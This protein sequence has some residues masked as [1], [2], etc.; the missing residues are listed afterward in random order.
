MAVTTTRAE[1]ETLLRQI[2]ECRE[3][4][5]V[6]PNL[7][8][9]KLL[10][11]WNTDLVLMAQA[12]SEHGVRKSGVH[13][14]DEQGNLR[15]P[16]GTYLDGYLRRVGYSIDP[17]ES[18]L[19]R[20]YSTNVLHCWP[21]KG[22]K[23]DRPPKASELQNCRKWWQAELRLLR[24]KAIVL[25]GAPAAEAFAEAC[26]YC[27]G[28]D[29]L[30]VNQDVQAEFDGVVTRFFTVPHPTAPFKGPLGGRSAYFEL[31]F[32]ALGKRLAADRDVY[33][34]A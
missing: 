15:P 33:T 31:A 12:P 1:L 32:E 10:E 22:A 17:F 3:C 11:G 4:V 20:P 8:P 13:W 2:H 7:V 27:P 29:W 21:G 16:G 23:R 9:R 24:P 14:L 19:P 28:F 6:I 18:R 34:G 26:G 30:L 5:S 25:L